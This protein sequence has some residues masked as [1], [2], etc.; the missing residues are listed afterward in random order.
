[1]HIKHMPQLYKGISRL[2]SNEVVCTIFDK[3]KG[4]TNPVYSYFDE[5]AD[6]QKQTK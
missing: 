4:S 6:L 1:M 3:Q 5:G 2:I